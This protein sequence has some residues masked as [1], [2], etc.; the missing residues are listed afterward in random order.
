MQIHTI[1]IYFQAIQYCMGN[2]CNTVKGKNSYCTLYT[3]QCT[4]C[5]RAMGR[6]G[7]W[8][9]EI[10]ALGRAVDPHP[11]FADP[12]PAVLLNADQDPA[13]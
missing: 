7:A 4:V 2:F 1:G 12:D 11:F 13:A 9:E 5:S 8:S 6:V 3:E 10:V